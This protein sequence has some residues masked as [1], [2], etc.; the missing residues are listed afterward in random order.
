MKT[1]E[2]WLQITAGQG[3]IE[4]AW[5]V[6][7]VIEK[8]HTEA[9]TAKLETKTLELEPGPVP[10]TAHSA[11]LTISGSN[12]EPFLAHWQGTIQWIARSPFR[13]THKRRNWFVG[14]DVLEPVEETRFSIHEVKWETMRAS[15]PGGQHVNRTESAVRV[16][17]L[18]T[19]IQVHAA[20][21]RSQHR[22]RKLALARLA[23]KL[24]DIQTGEHD[25][26]RT[27][28]WKAHQ[29]LQRGSP[30]RIF[31]GEDA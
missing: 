20:E 28:R 4:C 5:A 18:P 6:I 17:H 21:E 30:T 27:Q 1:E 31:R 29:D 26:A 9:A 12:L 13:P 25:K 8:L 14:I 22:N 2:R 10:G 24:A 23:Q 7:K 16:T 15:G 3:P 19:G 11:L